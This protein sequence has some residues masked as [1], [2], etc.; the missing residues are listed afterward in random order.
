MFGFVS[1][2]FYLF[3]AFLSVLWSVFSAFDDPSIE[4]TQYE[5]AQKNSLLKTKD[6][7]E[8]ELRQLPKYRLEID[9]KIRRSSTG[10]AFYIGNNKWLTARHVINK[11]PQVFLEQN[12]SKQ[13]IERIIIHPNSDLAIF[14]HSPN[15]YLGKF[16]LARDISATSFASGYPGGYPGDVTLSFLGLTAMEE[17]GYNILEKHTVF[18]ISKKEPER[19]VSFGGISGGPSY[20]RFGNVNGVVVAESVRRGLLFAVSIEQIS[21]LIAASYKGAVLSQEA[22]D[23]NDGN[24]PISLDRSFSEV[25]EELR[26]N[27]IVSKVFCKV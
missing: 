25:G 9:S 27:G 17:R 22:L 16:S 24:L 15:L 3:I 1:K 5:F 4:K 18:A 2:N 19:L 12:S 7:N 10:T 23:K 26:E 13:L 6:I 20:D 14:E 8:V 21:W 11:C